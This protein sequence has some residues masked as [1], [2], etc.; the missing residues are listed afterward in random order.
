MSKT[1]PSLWLGIKSLNY[2]I[3]LLE[4]FYLL[5]RQKLTAIFAAFREKKRLVSHSLPA[6][7]VSCLV[8]RYSATE[9][10]L[11]SMCPFNL[12]KMSVCLFLSRVLES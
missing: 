1:A 4:H 8:W 6:Q 9:P 12:V 7:K 11:S 5:A 3:Y 10:Y 2:Y